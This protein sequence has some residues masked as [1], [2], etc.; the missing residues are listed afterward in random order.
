MQKDTQIFDL[1]EQERKRQTSG[2]EL[3]AS[4]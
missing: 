1:I 3:I 4:E 2:L